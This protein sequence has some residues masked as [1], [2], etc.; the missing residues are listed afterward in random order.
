MA[1]PS[2]EASDNG[3]PAPPT[4]VTGGSTVASLAQLQNSLTSLLSA[5]W[6]ILMPQIGES[7]RQQVSEALQGAGVKQGQQGRG[8]GGEY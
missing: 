2:L 8:A 1:D 5:S 6:S 4:T 3:P 7:I